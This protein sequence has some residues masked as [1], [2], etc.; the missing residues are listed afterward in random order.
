MQRTVVYRLEGNDRQNVNDEI[1]LDSFLSYTLAE[2]LED[3]AS[4]GIRLIGANGP[5][6]IFSNHSVQLLVEARE[7]IDP[8]QLDE[9]TKLLVLSSVAMRLPSYET[10]RGLGL[11]C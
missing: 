6:H 7:R 4:D 8:A 3:L 1:G 9:D 2:H 5:A 10:G 11:A